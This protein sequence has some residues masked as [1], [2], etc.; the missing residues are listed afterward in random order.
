MIGKKVGEDGIYVMVSEGF[1]EGMI[2]NE[3]VF[4]CKKVLVGLG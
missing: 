2:L 3:V 1:F 4:R